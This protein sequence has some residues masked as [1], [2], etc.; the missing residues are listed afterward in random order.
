MALHRRTSQ[1]FL[2]T[3][4]GSSRINMGRP[5]RD[6]RRSRVALAA[7]LAAQLLCGVTE[8]TSVGGSSTVSA[9]GA[10]LRRDGSAFAAPPLTLRNSGHV[11]GRHHGKAGRAGILR[12][13][14]PWRMSMEINPRDSW[15]NNVNNKRYGTNNAFFFHTAAQNMTLIAATVQTNRIAGV[16]MDH[17][18]AA[19]AV[20]EAPVLGAGTRD[21]YSKDIGRSV[22]TMQELGGTPPEARPLSGLVMGKIVIDEFV[23]RKQ[24]DTKVPCRP[25]ARCLQCQQGSGFGA[26][27]P[28]RPERPRRT[29]RARIV[30]SERARPPVDRARGLGRREPA[31]GTRGAALGRQVQGGAGGACRAEV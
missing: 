27:A 24:P 11:A 30:D 10:V 26:F 25:P 3:L 16:A 19:F 14:L 17:P 21:W 22:L 6:E 20:E 12:P 13:S 9:G 8:G 23:L 28:K 18:A 31:G 7:S 4:A 1:N 29:S 2:E 5:M 15:G